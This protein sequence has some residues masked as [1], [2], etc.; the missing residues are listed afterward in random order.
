MMLSKADL[1][2]PTIKEHQCVM[3]VHSHQ[4][5]TY[6]GNIDNYSAPL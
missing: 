6:E 3:E 4:T 5:W 1:L 2:A